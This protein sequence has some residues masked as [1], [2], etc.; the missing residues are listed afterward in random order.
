MTACQCPECRELDSVPD[1]LWA[2][3]KPRRHT[4]AARELV[5]AWRY[6][7]ARRMVT[8]ALEEFERQTAEATR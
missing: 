6:V 2:T 5:A 1:G 4:K 7:Q 3:T 8:A